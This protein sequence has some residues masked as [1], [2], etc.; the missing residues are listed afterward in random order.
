MNSVIIKTQYVMS[1]P[2][3]EKKLNILDG[4]AN[5]VKVSNMCCCT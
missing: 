5:N 4:G 1:Y 3:K 2:Q